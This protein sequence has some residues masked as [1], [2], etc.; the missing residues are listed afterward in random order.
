LGKSLDSQHFWAALTIVVA[1]SRA[2]E[3]PTVE[4]KQS[5]LAKCAVAFV[6]D[7]ADAA[8]TSKAASC[9]RRRAC[10]NDVVSVPM[11][12]RAPDPPGFDVAAVD[13]LCGS[14]SS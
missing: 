13:R 14:Y 11:V 7:H 2:R 1:L 8:S 5:F 12:A 9:R 3:G 10:G 4:Q 6:D